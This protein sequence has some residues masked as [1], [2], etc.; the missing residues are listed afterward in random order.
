MR[1]ALGTAILVTARF[2]WLLSH[3]EKWDT[4]PVVPSLVFCELPLLISLVFFFTGNKTKRALRGAGL[5]FGT[6]FGFCLL[7]PPMYIAA[8][9]T[10]WDTQTRYR[11]LVALQHFLPLCLVVAAC[12]LVIAWPYA[13]NSRSAFVAA[14]GMGVACFIVASLLIAGTSVRGSGEVKEKTA[15]EPP[16]TQPEKYV[17]VVTAC[18]IRHQFLH[19][20]EGF[21]ASLKDVRPDWKCD[22]VIGDP[23][24]LHGYWI[25]YS[26]VRD[27]SAPH[28]KDFRLETV[29]IERGRNFEFVAAGDRRGEAFVFLGLNASAAERKEMS[30]RGHFSVQTV[31]QSPLISEFRTIQGNIRGYMETHDPTN[32]PSSLEGVVNPQLIHRSCNEDEKLGEDLT[33]TERAIRVSS[34]KFCFSISYF[35]PSTT[36]SDTF[37]V[38]IT[39]MSYGEGCLRSYFRDYDGSEHATSEPRAATAQDPGLLPCE[40]SQVCNDPVWTSAEQASDWMFL[41][42]NVL[43]S[44]HTARWW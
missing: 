14:A 20:E 28:G 33:P 34:E 18:L 2:A 7:A 38:A 35:P 26:T 19:P 4:P 21:P 29:P 1:L 25:F 5:A 10:I 43:E 44:I 22:A 6:A 13:K 32:A 31:D 42:A 23:G 9:M 37:A 36:A 11:S 24:A 17:R 39:C 15:Y 27:D 30:R 12:I 3:A 8:G 40:T 41:K 16:V